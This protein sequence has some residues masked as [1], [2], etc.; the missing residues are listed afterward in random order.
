MATEQT[1]F[2]NHQTL[3]S[4]AISALSQANSMSQS[5]LKLLQ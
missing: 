2:T 4:A 5:L 3:T 1:N